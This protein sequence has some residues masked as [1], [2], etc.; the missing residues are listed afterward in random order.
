MPIRRRT[1]RAAT[2]CALALLLTVSTVCR[3]SP[4]ANTGEL[5]AAEYD[6]LLAFID[7]EFASRKGKEPLE[8]LGNGIAQI[9][10]F[11]MTESGEQRS[12]LRM[13]GNGQP[14]PWAQTASSLQNKVPALQQT[15]IDAYRRVNAQQAFLRR[16]FCPPIEYELVDSTQLDAIFK[17]SGWWPAYYKQF[18]GSQSILTFSRVGFSA[19]G[20]EALFYLSNR[21]G[22]LCGTGEYVV[23]EKRDG[24]WVIGKE[25]EMWIS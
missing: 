2:I 21:C 20:T 4:V 7:S 18:P 13:D 17:K 9:V 10:V 25:I 22:D 5:S 14:I 1:T 6:V 23:M 24:R 16:S 15:T 8:P 3:R 11:N 12:N 19:G